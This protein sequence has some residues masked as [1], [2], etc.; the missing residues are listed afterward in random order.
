[1]E[2]PEGELTI[3][4]FYNTVYPLNKVVDVDYYIPGCPPPTCLV[5]DAVKAIAS[6]NLPPKGSVLAP[7]LAVCDHCDR[8]KT[9]KRVT[10]IKR[11]IYD[12]PDP[13]K[14]LLEQGFLCLGAATRGA[15]EAKCPKANMP[16]VGCGGILPGSLEQGSAMISALSTVWGLDN[17]KDEDFD[18]DKLLSELKD[19]VG[20]F[21]KFSLPS[22]IIYRR[23]MK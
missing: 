15:C 1:M 22:S 9:N 16:C 13:G 5:I 21:Y 19:P 2:V 4:H 7:E 23:I 14:C 3:P 20:T 11:I 10:E 12:T 6:G 17:E 8:E 18:F